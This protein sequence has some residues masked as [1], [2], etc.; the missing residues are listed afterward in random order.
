MTILIY[1]PAHL[2]VGAQADSAHEYFLKHYLMTAQE[3]KS[4]LE[5]CEPNLLMI[6][7]EFHGR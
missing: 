3:D 1:N 2:S 5:M 4:S 7:S 6:G